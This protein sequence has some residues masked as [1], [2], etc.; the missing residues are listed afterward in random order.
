MGSFFCILNCNKITTGP[1]SQ[2]LRAQ[3]T[4]E[5]RGD[6]PLEPHL[7]PV[8]SA[9]ETSDLSLWFFEYAEAH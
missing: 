2:G 7:S 6:L 3:A 9:P 4:G 1:R 5:A 8:T